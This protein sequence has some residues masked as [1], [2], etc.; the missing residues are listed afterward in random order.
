M[1]AT[2]II[3]AGGN[4]TRMGED[5][6]MLA[7][8]NKPVIQH[9]ADQLSPCFDEVIIGSN[10][11]DKYQFLNLKTVCDK[12]MNQGPLMGILSTLLKSDNELNFVVACDI[13]QLNLELIDKMLKLASGYDIVMPVTEAGKYEPLFAVYKKSVIPYAEEI[14]EGGQRKVTSMFDKANV[15]YVKLDSSNKLWNLNTKK[16]YLEWK[17]TLQE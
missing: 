3:L 6:S 13:P 8:N 2:A 17:A 9:I 16:D 1:M 12:E 5:K 14:L 11:V 15:K 7:V 4:S 10:D